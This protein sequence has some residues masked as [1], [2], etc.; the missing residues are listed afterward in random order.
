V[1]YL[2]RE[3][4]QGALSVAVAEAMAAPVSSYAAT[5]SCW[6]ATLATVTPASVPDTYHAALLAGSEAGY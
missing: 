3:L 2:V 5:E 4:S 1:T 6:W